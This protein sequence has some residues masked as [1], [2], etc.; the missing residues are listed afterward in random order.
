LSGVFAL[1]SLR[2][3]TQEQLAARVVAHVRS[4]EHGGTAHIHIAEK[5][6]EVM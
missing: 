2:A 1:H 4:K 6:R 3:V 5:E